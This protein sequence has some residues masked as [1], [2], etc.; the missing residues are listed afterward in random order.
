MLGQMQGHAVV[1]WIRILGF[2]TDKCH[3]QLWLLY[4]NK[5]MRIGL[6]VCYVACEL[7]LFVLICV[8][9]SMGCPVPSTPVM[10]GRL[11]VHFQ[12]YSRSHVTM[13]M[14]CVCVCA[15]LSVSILSREKHGHGLIFLS[16]CSALTCNHRLGLWV[17]GKLSVIE[18]CAAVLFPATPLHAIRQVRLV[19]HPSFSHSCVSLHLFFLSS[20]SWGLIFMEKHKVVILLPQSPGR[21]RETW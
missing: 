17:I 21:F 10:S 9:L 4:K 5:W 20:V 7:Y 1:A 6:G 18:C 12:A 13:I 15:T 19:H 3:S 8:C 2:E 11:D 16:S 14:I